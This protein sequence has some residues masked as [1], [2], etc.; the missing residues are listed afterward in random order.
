MSRPTHPPSRSSGC[1]PD[2]CTRRLFHH[3][4]CGLCCAPTTAAAPSQPRPGCIP[5]GCLRRFCAW[6]WCGCC[7]RPLEAAPPRPPP[8]VATAQPRR[9]RRSRAAV[10]Q[11]KKKGKDQ[12]AEAEVEAEAKEAKGKAENNSLEELSELLKIP[13]AHTE[14]NAVRLKRYPPSPVADDQLRFFGDYSG[15]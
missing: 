10:P 2:D 11:S 5:N 6:L 12:A 14:R 4:F 3:L 1:R 15:R 8:L 13:S 9:Q 7:C